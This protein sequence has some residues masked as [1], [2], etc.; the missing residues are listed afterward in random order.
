MLRDA[1]DKWKSGYYQNLKVELEQMHP[2]IDNNLGKFL[3]FFQPFSQN[4]FNTF[5][6]VDTDML[7]IIAE[8]HDVKS[9]KRRLAWMISH[10]ANFRLWN[11]NDDIS[12]TKMSEYENIYFLELKDL[13][14][15]KFLEWLRKQDKEWEGVKSINKVS[16]TGELGGWHTKLHQHEDGIVSGED[17]W[18]CFTPPGFWASMDLF[19]KEYK[20]CKILKGKVLV[21]PFY[22]LEGNK[23]ISLTTEIGEDIFEMVKREQDTVDFIRE[24]HERYISKEF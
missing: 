8:M 4:L 2:K 18:G 17:I 15:P 11:N 21:C 12:L 1:L 16:S 22:E 6:D 7:D 24:S 19:W 14:N 13:S 20:E 3:S 10:H 9:G 5:V 23:L